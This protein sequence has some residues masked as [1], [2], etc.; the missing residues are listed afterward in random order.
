MTQH[1]F[2]D[3][4]RYTRVIGKFLFFFLVVF[5]TVIVL[6]SSGVSIIWEREKV[7]TSLTI[8]F[9]LID[10]AVGAALGEMKSGPL[11]FVWGKS[12][13]LFAIRCFV[14]IALF[15]FLIFIL[16]TK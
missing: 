16:L 3:G 9:L 12:P 5:F 4:D 7:L 2:K 13:V 8:A 14:S 15:V 6:D 10:L 1:E 11:A